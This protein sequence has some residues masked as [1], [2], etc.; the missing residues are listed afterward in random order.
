MRI[1]SIGNELQTRNERYT[2]T[3]LVGIALPTNSQLSRIQIFFLCHFSSSHIPSCSHRHTATLIKNQFNILNE[4]RTDT[5]IVRS[6][7]KDV[8]VVNTTHTHIRIHYLIKNI[9]KPQ[10]YTLLSLQMGSK[11]T[12][13]KPRASER[14]SEHGVKI[15]LQ[16][17]RCGKP[18][19][20][21]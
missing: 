16:C 21:M 11:V 9:L 18:G 2:H 4:V 17:A 12:G 7:H 13:E 3:K 6:T 15:V 19:H 14:S 1:S 20:C 10:K 5:H 8:G